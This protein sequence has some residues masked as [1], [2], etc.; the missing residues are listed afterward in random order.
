V[1]PKRR[2]GEKSNRRLKKENQ[3]IAKSKKGV[4]GSWKHFGETKKKGMGDST[5]QI[6]SG[7]KRSGSGEWPPLSGTHHQSQPKLPLPRGQN[8]GNRGGSKKKEGHSRVVPISQRKMGGSRWHPGGKPKPVGNGGDGEFA[9]ETSSPPQK[10]HKQTP[11]DK[12]KPAKAESP[13]DSKTRGRVKRNRQT[14]QR[15]QITHT[16]E[17]HPRVVRAAGGKTSLRKP[18]KGE[19][20]LFKE[21]KGD[22]PKK[23]GKRGRSRQKNA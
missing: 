21:I 14:Q 18:T 7:K 19:K 23:K 12:K 6:R 4:R 8:R 11:P 9:L 20:D 3:P 15:D 13:S 17:S 22:T 5:Q 16:P 2:R 1:P 10:K